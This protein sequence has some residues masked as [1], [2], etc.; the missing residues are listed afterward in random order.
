MKR[1]F[2]S[3]LTMLECCT[4]ASN[5]Y[6][7]DTNYQQVYSFYVR[8]Q[9]HPNVLRMHNNHVQ[10][11]CFSTSKVNLSLSLVEISSETPS[12]RDHHRLLHD[13]NE[14]GLHLW[15]FIF[16]N[17]LD[18]PAVCKLTLFSHS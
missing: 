4:N 15:C 7:T 9:V 11:M 6:I 3:L 8:P 5:I 1:C 17:Q 2:F 10:K 12:T 14:R 13:I 18:S 16:K